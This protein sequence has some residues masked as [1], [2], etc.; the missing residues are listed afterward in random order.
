MLSIM[1][2]EFLLS[3]VGLLMRGKKC[4]DAKIFLI[5]QLP[6]ESQWLEKYQHFTHQEEKY[7]SLCNKARVLVIYELYFDNLTHG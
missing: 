2:T 3:R 6:D 5:P 4:S 1:V 7:I